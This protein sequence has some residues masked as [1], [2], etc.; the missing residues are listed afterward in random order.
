MALTHFSKWFWSED[1][2]LPPGY[3]WESLTQDEQFTYPNFYDVWTYPFVIAALFIA[4]R[5]L[6]LTPFVFSPIGLALGVK[7]IRSRPP[8]PSVTME[9]IFHQYRSRAPE[10]TVRKAADTL[11][12]TERQVERWLRQRASSARTTDLGK[13][14]NMAWETTY[15]T[16]YCVFGLV[17]LWDKPW[18]WD[19]RHCWYNF[20]KHDVDADIWWYY[21]IAVGYYWCMTITHTIQHQRKDS[22][23]LFAHHVLT[24]LLISCSWVCNFARLGSLVLVLHECADIP[25]LLA[26][27]FKLC[28]RKDIMDK[29]FV[30]FLLVWLTT[31]TG[32]FPIWILRSTLFQAHVVIG[33]WYPV[34]YIFNGMLLLLLLIHIGWTYLI[35]R[36]VVRKVRYNEMEDV[37]S[38]TDYSL[39]DDEED[40]ES[41]KK[42]L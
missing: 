15:Y 22:L 21:M 13:F 38:S 42:D 37:R 4:L 16:L 14:S 20:P 32:L 36:I 8:P 27:M 31:R 40:E 10:E 12:W 18:L 29:L 17:V 35:L 25:M 1:V 30:V 39:E 2:W 28:G 5:Y 11:G 34:Y 33:A 24:I 23:Q 41:Q 19:I 6:V 26:K 9:A 3:T 7:D